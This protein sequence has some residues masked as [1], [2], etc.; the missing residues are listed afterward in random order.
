[1]N[2]RTRLPRKG[3]CLCGW[4]VHPVPCRHC[5]RNNPPPHTHTHTKG[6]YT[7]FMLYVCGSDV[8]DS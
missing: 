8:Q 6:Q 4:A 1:M 5:K 3:L 7:S 2:G